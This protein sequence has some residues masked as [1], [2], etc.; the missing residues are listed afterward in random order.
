MHRLPALLQDCVDLIEARPPQGVGILSL[1]DEECIYPRGTD[2]SFATKLRQR[3]V[4]GGAE[5]PVL[6]LLCT[7]RSWLQ[8]HSRC[9]TTHAPSSCLCPLQA[10]HPRFSYNP[11][12]P[13]DDFTLQHYA[14]PVVYSCE[15]FLDKNKDTLS[16]GERPWPPSCLGP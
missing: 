15:K 13:S 9:C 12:S 11:K 7:C 2:S 4:R 10:A 6:R 3:Q 8:L 5:R 14:G 1:L 16:P